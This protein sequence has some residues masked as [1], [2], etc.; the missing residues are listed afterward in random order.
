MGQRLAQQV[1]VL[2]RPAQTVGL[3]GLKIF[4]T[5]PPE[6][7]RVN[8]GSGAHYLQ[9]SGLGQLHIINGFIQSLVG[10]YDYATLTGDT[11]A[12]VLFQQAERAPSLRLAL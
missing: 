2:D 10:L 12:Q 4:Q 5:P 11:T 8:E 9:Y 1:R 7:V 6:G 3:A